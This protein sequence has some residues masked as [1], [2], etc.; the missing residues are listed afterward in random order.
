MIEIATRRPARSTLTG[1]ILM[2]ALVLLAQSAPGLLKI[3]FEQK[4]FVH[5]HRQ[6]WDFCLVRDGVS[7]HLFYH[8]IHEDTPGAAYA[9]T[10]WHASSPDLYHWSILG[11]AITSGPGWWDKEAIWAPDVAWDPV[12]QSWVMVYTGVDS[13]M[14]Q[15]AC[16]AHSTNLT[17]WHKNPH[18]PV[19][20]PDSLKYYWSPTTEWSSF[21]DP[22]IF[23]ENGVW[24][25]LSTA[26]MREN[27]YPGTRRGIIHHATSTSLV[28]W[29]DKGYFFVNNGPN[30]S[31]EMESSQYCVRQGWHHLFF[32]ETNVPGTSHLVSDTQGGWDFADWELL[33]RGAAPEIDEFDPGISIFSRIGIDRHEFNNKLFYVLRF[34]TLLFT[35]GGQT[36]QIYKP[37]PLARDWFY[38]SGSS[39]L[40]NPTFG[41]NTAER[42]EEPCG[43]VG[44]GWFG[45]QEFYQGPLSGKG[46]PGDKLGDA[47]TGLLLS[48]DFT[49]T[50]SYI[51]LKVGGGYYPE[52]CYVGLVDYHTGQFLF[53]E[54]GHGG[55]TMVWRV[56]DVRPY[57]G[58]RVR[59]VIRD[60]EQ[61][62]F[63]HIN[64][65]EITEMEDTLT[66]VPASAAGVLVD[67][68]PLP[69]PSNPATE[70]RFALASAARAVIRVYDLRGKRIWES[71]TLALQAGTH[72]VL[73]NGRDGD[74]RPLATGVYLYGIELNGIL[75]GSG[76]VTLVK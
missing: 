9:D 10:I 12:R 46:T 42:G 6:V 23:Y 35:D 24:N 69:N 67:H 68:R 54:T 41:D 4:Y 71:D 45:S 36:P 64:V 28:D 61:G 11:P 65:D 73:W 53:K 43:M 29:V 60:D 47:A 13:L 52:T 27:G 56:W 74:G 17:S 34:D 30:P 1:A 70:I 8:T 50:G 58:R 32:A 3:D 31:H 72:S 63:G 76:K 57:Q 5:P 75:A 26:G 25:M 18:N 48:P 39:T 19:F 22:F 37:D 38:W 66:D 7:Y 16:T 55:E 49:V 2:L 21:R 20:E 15:R 33:E 62:Y 51:Q 14:V 59:I 44:N 40:A